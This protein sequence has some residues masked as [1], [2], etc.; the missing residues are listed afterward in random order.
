MQELK[1]NLQ[2][3]ENALIAVC[4]IVMTLSAFAQVVNRNFIGAGISWFDELARYCMV[5]LTLLATEAGLRDG[6]QIAITAITD[7]CTPAVR[8]A[9]QIIVKVIIIG[10]SIAILMTSMD[11]VGMQLRSGQVSAAMNLPMWIPYASLPLCFGIITIVQIIALVAL[12]MS[13]LSS[14]KPS[15][16]KEGA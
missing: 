9:L 4:F 3:F 7:K 5:Y 14:D 2:R 8:R 16:K 13:P 1:L 6:S 11:L 10:F 15:E 12:C